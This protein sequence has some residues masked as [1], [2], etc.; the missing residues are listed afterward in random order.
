MSSSNHWGFE[1]GT[2]TC[3]FALLLCCTY[4]VEAPWGSTCSTKVWSCFSEHKL[5]LLPNLRVGWKSRFSAEL[6]IVWLV[7]EER[8]TGRGGRQEKE[9]V[10]RLGKR[11]KLKRPEEHGEGSKKIGLKENLLWMTIASSGKWQIPIKAYKIGR[12]LKCTVRKT[13]SFFICE[14]L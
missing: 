11:R 5:L 6:D 12:G 8:K 13:W 9:D 1:K 3:S 7:E 4:I 10:V 2:H 14:F